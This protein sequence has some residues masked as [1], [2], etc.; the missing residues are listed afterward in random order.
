MRG[1]CAQHRRLFRPLAA[2]ARVPFA[3]AASDAGFAAGVG[4]FATPPHGL[5]SG[6]PFHTR[7]VGLARGVFVS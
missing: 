4:P 3:F 2:G 5:C 6:D 1:A 7:G